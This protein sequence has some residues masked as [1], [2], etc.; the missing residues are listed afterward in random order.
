MQARDLFVP[1]WI[2]TIIVCL[3]PALQAQ[4]PQ[5]ATERQPLGNSVPGDALADLP[6]GATIFSL[7][8]TA[9]PEVISDRVDAGSLTAGQPA[10]MG[11]HGSSWTQTMFRIG[12]VD[13]SDPAA[14]GTPLILPGVLAWQRMDV[15]TGA[16]QLGTNAPRLAVTLGPRP[17][18]STG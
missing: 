16:M 4:S 11:A 18:A 8:D 9:I 3:G 12:E 15:S 13:V 2:A 6:S 10:R 7:L 1:A 17:T 14:N 5:P